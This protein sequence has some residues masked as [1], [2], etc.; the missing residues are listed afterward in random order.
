MI[1]FCINL[2]LCCCV[3][4]SMAADNLLLE[5]E[6]HFEE[7]E[8]QQASKSW[9]DGFKFTLQ[10]SHTQTGEGTQLQRSS[11]QLE[12]EY[13]IAD[14]WYTH[15]KGKIRH[16]WSND[17]QAE[18]RNKSYTHFQAQ[19]AWVQYSQAACA[20]KLGKQ[21]LIWGEVEGTFAVDIV[22]PFDYT[23]QLL[24][25][26]SSIRLSQ[27][28]LQSECFFEHVQTELFYLPKAR[29]DRFT[30]ER[31]DVSFSTGS[32]WGG[33]IKYNWAGGDISLMYARLYNNTPVPILSNDLQNNTPQL[34]T[35]DFDFFG[36]SSSIARGRLLMKFDLGYKRK[37]LVNLSTIRTDRL[38]F[39]TGIEYT[40]S[41]NHNINAG[42]WLIRELDNTAFD[43]STNFTIG[44]SKAYLNDDL[45]M[46]LLAFASDEP[47]QASLTIQGQYK[48]NDYWTLSSALGVTDIDD[49]IGNSPL[50]QP[51]Q[52]ITLSAKYEF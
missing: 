45:S 47:E 27:T 51:K 31:D 8:L 40:T 39:A 4:S 1:R 12:Y 20:Y 36:I 18:Q 29:T 37:Q 14:G 21:Q 42:L 28:M 52:S 46:S 24:T 2:L 23:E 22:T 16:F 26:F 6:Y 44:W 30:H 38:D 48:W 15:L 43:E 9:V 10:H 35:D 3:T 49:D 17:R 5:D 32:E 41:S 19:Q 33:R 25:D 7:Q 13:A 34:E 11:T 50:A